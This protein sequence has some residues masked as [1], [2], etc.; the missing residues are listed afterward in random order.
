MTKSEILELGDREVSVVIYREDSPIRVNGIIFCEITDGGLGVYLLHDSV[1]DL[2][3]SNPKTIN[4]RGTKYVGSWRFSWD[5]DD[6]K[7]S[8]NRGDGIDC[9]YSIFVM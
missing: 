6:F 1:E 5:I 7:I 3:G 8:V 9:P 2:R 4:M